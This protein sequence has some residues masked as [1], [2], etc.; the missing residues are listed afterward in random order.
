[1]LLGVTAS[2][3][4]NQ[5]SENA[6]IFENVFVILALSNSACKAMFRNR[7]ESILGEE[8]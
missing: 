2:S 1:M 4:L 5:Y 7:Y 8:L 6:L 3:L